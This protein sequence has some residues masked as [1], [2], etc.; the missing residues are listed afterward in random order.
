LSSAVAFATGLGRR[1]DAIEQLPG[2]GLEPLSLDSLNQL[3]SEMQNLVQLTPPAPV[4]AES[5]EAALDLVFDQL[6]VDTTGQRHRFKKKHPAQRSTREAY[7]AHGIPSAAIEQS[8]KISSGAYGDT[9][10]FAV[11]NGHAVQLVQCWSF[12]LPNQDDL[13]ERVKAWSWVVHELRQ[14][15]GRVRTD[16]GELEVP[17]QTEIAAVSIPPI[18]GAEAPA[19]AEAREAFRENG[20]REVSLEQADSVGATAADLLAEAGIAISD[21][22]LR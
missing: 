1:I 9:F 22:R 19:Y 5:A 15:G 4:V 21:A 13:A 17:S 16:R 14:R 6:V 11:H 12:Q 3:A 18:D 10:D 8:A 2:S 7:R 20:V